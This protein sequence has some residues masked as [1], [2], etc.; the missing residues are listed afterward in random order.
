MRQP[1]ESEESRGIGHFRA[2]RLILLRERS[3][4]RSDFDERNEMDDGGRSG[5]I[6]PKSIVPGHAIK[7]RV[8]GLSGMRKGRYTAAITLAQA[9]RNIVSV[10]RT[11]RIR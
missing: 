2:A 10:T 1:T 5:G 11:F 4:S 9:G 8:L 7:L 3:E 6:S